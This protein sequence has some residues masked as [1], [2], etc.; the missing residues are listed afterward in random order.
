MQALLFE[1]GKYGPKTAAKWATTKGYA[2]IKYHVTPNFVRARIRQ[3]V[4]GSRY[5]MSNLSPHVRAVHMVPKGKGVKR[6]VRRVTVRKR[7]TSIGMRKGGS[8]LDF[9]VRNQ[10]AVGWAL[11]AIDKILPLAAA[12]GISYGIYKGVKKAQGQGIRGRRRRI[13]RRTKRVR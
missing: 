2:P 6:H 3:P 11:H 12:T 1:R 10:R 5:W 4:P 13:V 9:L 8:V 7:K